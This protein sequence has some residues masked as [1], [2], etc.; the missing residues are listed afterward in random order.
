MTLSVQPAAQDAQRRG[1]T[2]HAPAVVKSG[3]ERKNFHV[4]HLG[5]FNQRAGVRIGKHCRGAAT[6]LEI[7]DPGQVEPE[8]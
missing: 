3:Y 5:E 2:D 1:K 7:I 6:L 4:V 8:K